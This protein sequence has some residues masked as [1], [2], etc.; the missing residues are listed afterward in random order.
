MRMHSALPY[1]F[2]VSRQARDRYGFEQTL[3]ATNGRVV[4]ANFLAARQFAQKINDQRDLAAHPEQAITAGQVNAMGLIA[5]TLHL[6]VDQYRQQQDGQVMQAALDWLETRLGSRSVDDLLLRFTREFPPV[7]VYQGQLTAEQYLAAASVRSD[8]SLAAN[9]EIALEELLMLWLQNANPAYAALQ[10]LYSDAGLALGTV[11]PQAIPD[12]QQF[13]QSRPPAG[14]QGLTLFDLLRAPALAH[15]DSLSA[16]LAFMRV[17]WVDAGLLPEPVYRQVL[18]GED[19]VREEQKPGFAGGGPP[20]AEVYDFTSADYWYEPEAF[21]PDLEWMPNLVLIAKNAYVWLDQLSTK[22]QRAINRLDQVPDAELDA[23]ARAGING[24]WLIGLWERSPASRRIKQMRGAAEAVASAYSLFAYDIAADLGG[25]EAYQALR[26]QAGKRGIRLASDMVPNHMG[27]D[28]RWVIEHPDWFVALDYSPFP[29]YTFK[30]TNLS[31]DGRVGIY[32]ED[33]YYDNTDAAVVFKRVDFW[34]GSEKYIY[35]GNDG[36]ALPWNDTAQ[37]N[38]LL[39]EVR[40]AVIQTILHVARK[41]PII[42]FD[43]AMTLAKR[44][45]QRLW[46]PEPGSG[47]DIPSRAEFG[48]T[49]EQFDQV[50]PEEFWRE[51]VDRVAAEAPDTLLLA[52]AFWL[53]EGYFVR[54]LG[55]HRVY[56]SAFMNMLR[57]E[58]NQEYRLVIKNTIEFDPEILQRYVNFMSNPDERTA[59]DQFGKGDKYFGVSAMMA[60]LP[61]LP[62][63]GHGQIEGYTEKYGMEFRYAM[64]KEKVDEDLLRR[65]E[66]L[67]FPLLRRRALFAQAAN[68]LLYDFFTAD[69]RVNEDVF[70]YSNRAGDEH[71]LVVYH[72]RYASVSGWINRSAA[73]ALKTPGSDEKPL[74]QR[75]LS[76]ALE[77]HAES[78]PANEPG[79]FVILRDHVKRL[80][81]LRSSVEL[82][83]VGLYLDL[84][85]YDCR[86]Y[87]DIREIQDEPDGRY[88]RLAKFLMGGG[89]PSIEDALLEMD[90]QDVLV[91]YRELVNP[92]M[93][94]W[95]LQNRADSE[96]FDPARHEMAL[97]EA[98]LKIRRILSAVDQHSPAA[99]PEALPGQGE[100]PETQPQPAAAAAPETPPA[101]AV[102]TPER[103][104][105]LDELAADIRQELDALLRLPVLGRSPAPATPAQAVA[106]EFL[107]S[108]P[109]DRRLL[110]G[111]KPLYWGPLLAAV[112]TARLGELQAERDPLQQSV[113]WMDELLLGKSITTML[114]GLGLDENAPRRRSDLARVLVRFQEWCDSALPAEDVAA[115]LLLDL[116]ADPAVRR[117]LLVHTYEGVQWFNKEA[118]EEL[119]W[120]LFALASVRL[121]AWAGDPLESLAQ[122]YA[123]ARLLLAAAVR[124]GYRFD[125]LA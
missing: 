23:L 4:F 16:Q 66:R 96:T 35:H 59:V 63:I 118:Y 28:S 24:L 7:A 120:S 68:F 61:G 54:T 107:Q 85:P 32:L 22:Y 55:M 87:L 34:T 91:P 58:K 19:L 102:E 110:H 15:P 116:K 8:G 108:G 81:Y 113:L 65:H 92:G 3:F 40:E 12:L 111:G 33:H 38:Y 6:L 109:G 5:E 106:L 99:L 2:H 123:L 67:I 25:E 77:L 41:F 104:A 50:F 70:A 80:E 49:K 44:H 37:L 57:D 13:F 30:G 47:G 94:D 27:I 101:P 14:P 78:Y 53:M 93:F 76:Q 122:C 115:R 121:S 17:E 18:T 39:P 31:W 119:V 46:F 74:V 42:R 90:L 9:R 95:L 60:T 83:T 105:E 71:S 73:Y 45:Y 56:N 103:A 51:V 84:G 82:S 20:P 117:L 48:L 43:A 97:A 79:Y 52:E 72:N 26:S 98:G 64:W 124:A 89:A 11:Y 100:L 112:L 21:S 114:A 36:T 69:G 62:M 1:E 10:E 88:A 125:L 75:T 86:V 29:T